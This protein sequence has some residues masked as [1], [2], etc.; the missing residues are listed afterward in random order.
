MLRIKILNKKYYPYSNTL[1]VYGLSLENIL[2]TSFV[3]IVILVLVASNRLPAKE[4]GDMTR[5]GQLK[6]K[7]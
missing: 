4:K 1:R 3:A 5:T 7:T 2:I 6:N